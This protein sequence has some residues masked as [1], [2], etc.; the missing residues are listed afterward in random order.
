ML[1]TL[2][3]DTG[4]LRKDLTF[5]RSMLKANYEKQIS[6]RSA[7]LYVMHRLS[8]NSFVIIILYYRYCRVNERLCN[9]EL[10]HKKVSII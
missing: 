1:R 10:L 8:I 7:E 6:D 2:T 5:A 3:L 4:Q 9:Y